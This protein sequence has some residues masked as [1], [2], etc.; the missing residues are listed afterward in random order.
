M[1]KNSIALV[2]GANSGIGKAAAA[3]LAKQDLNVVMLCRDKTRGEE[4]L[5]DIKEASGSD[6]IELMICDLSCTQ[7]INT[8]CDEF[9]KKHDRL[10]ILINNAGV[11]KQ[12]RR[13]TNYGCELCFGVNYLGAFLLTIRLLPLLKASAPARIVNVS[14]VAHRWGK[15]HF[16]DINITKRYTALKAYSQSKLAGLMFT[17][18]LAEKLTG[19]GVTV[20]AADPGVVGT[21]ITVNRETGFGSLASKAQKL[22]FKTPEKG[23]E[24]AVYLATS[25]DVEGVTG[26]FFRNKKAVRSAKRADDK[27][28]RERLWHLSERMV[29][30]SEVSDIDA[31]TG[32]YEEAPEI[33]SEGSAAEV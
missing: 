8:F 29:G 32:Y 17:Y 4:A 18:A 19:T 13:E 28:C 9:L 24:T 26:K 12:T 5:R 33:I 31:D 7:S 14:S 30:L 21:S 6:N 20:N 27:A 1:N 2:T 23:A 22:L 25:S 11:L 3:A 10:D 15:I 16:N